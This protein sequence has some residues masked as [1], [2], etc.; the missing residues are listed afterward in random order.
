MAEVHARG[1]KPLRQGAGIYEEQ[2]ASGLCRQPLMCSFAL[3]PLVLKST[4]VTLRLPS[5]ADVVNRGQGKPQGLMTS[6]RDVRASV[7]HALTRCETR[8][9]VSCHMSTTG[10][11]RTI[12]RPAWRILTAGTPTLMWNHGVSRKVCLPLRMCP[13][14]IV[15]RVLAVFCCNTTWL[16]TPTPRS[17]LRLC[18]EDP[19]VQWE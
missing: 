18:V 2:E 6:G 13:C 16:L 3:A 12:P 10:R 4:E 19:D 7:D 1:R 11:R 14:R 9:P 17:G 15:S 5:V 8:N